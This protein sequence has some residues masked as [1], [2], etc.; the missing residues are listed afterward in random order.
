MVTYVSKGYLSFL[1]NLLSTY[2]QDFVI[3]FFCKDEELKEKI[4]NIFLLALTNL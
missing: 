4:E 2:P 1:I 3:T